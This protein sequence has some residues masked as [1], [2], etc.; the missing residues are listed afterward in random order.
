MIDAAEIQ[1]Q[2]AFVGRSMIKNVELSRE[3]GY[4]HVD[5]KNIVPIEDIGKVSPGSLVVMTTGSQGEPFSGLVLMS[6]GEHRLL[7]L[8][9]RTWWP[10]S[11]RPFPETRRW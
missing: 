8:A 9:T 6:K 7:T 10:S 1:P 11:P 4:L 5:E 3:L 2:I